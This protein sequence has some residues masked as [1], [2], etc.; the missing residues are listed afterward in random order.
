MRKD[1]APRAAERAPRAELHHYPYHH[2]DIYSD[3]RAKAVQ[4]A[5]LQRT[6]QGVSA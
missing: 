2:F 1:L 6:V 5:F 4:V 3:P